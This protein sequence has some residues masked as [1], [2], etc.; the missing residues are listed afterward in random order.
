MLLKTY[1]QLAGAEASGFPPGQASW[2]GV[3]QKYIPVNKITGCLLL[4]PQPSYLPARA[5]RCRPIASSA[6]CP[7][8]AHS[9]TGTAPICLSMQDKTA[10]RAI[11]FQA[12]GKTL[13]LMALD[14]RPHA[15][16]PST[17][18]GH[19]QR[20]TNQSRAMKGYKG[21]SMGYCHWNAAACLPHLL[22]C[23]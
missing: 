12:R 16:G 22:P 15:R 1:G 8:R 11:L 14:G 6:S 10:A 9:G 3:W 18:E 17:W 19:P 21:Y 20:S 23:T 5:S 13:H 2:Q 4:Q 7:C